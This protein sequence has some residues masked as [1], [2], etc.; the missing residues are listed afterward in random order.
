M[1]MDRMERRPRVPLDTAVTYATLGLSVIPECPPTCGCH[2]P[3]KR[4]WDPV[5]G[6]HMTGWLATSVVVMKRRA[7]DNMA[8]AI[9]T[10]EALNDSSVNWTAF[11]DWKQAWPQWAGRYFGGG[12]NWS[13]GEFTAAKKA[14]GG[15]LVRIAPL[16]GSQA[17]RQQTAGSTGH[18]YG[19]SAA[20]ATCAN[21]IDAINA[22]Q[23]SLPTNEPVIV[24]LDVEQ[25]TSIM[26]AYW[27]GW[28]TTV[29]NY[30]HNG[31]APFL[32]GMY[33]DYVLDTS[34]NLYYP[35]S[36]VQTCLNTVCTYW[37]GDNY[38][39]YGLWANEPEPCSYASDSTAVPDWSVFGSFT[40]TGCGNKFPV[41]LY[42]YQ[43]ME[44]KAAVD[45]CGVSNFAGGND[46]D[47]DSSDDKGGQ[48]YMLAI[49]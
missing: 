46:F 21:I 25:G 16:Q 48:T 19:V 12:Y 44:H 39:C 1:G 36:S 37:P 14:T 32:P 10:T 6:Q 15:A 27:A 28:A 13:A 2:S 42:L 31:V 4:P 40:Q 5:A 43:H 7:G 45:T 3:C 29:Y 33:T 17:S 26:P 11:Y 9:D 30:V 24:Y 49:D 47:L 35:Q 20:N 23:L 34:N 41:P 18:E 22:S 38:F 8:W